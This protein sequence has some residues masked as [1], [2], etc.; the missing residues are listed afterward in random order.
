MLSLAVPAIPE[1][2][3][4]AY[5]IKFDGYRTEASRPEAECNLRSCYNANFNARFPAIARALEALPDETVNDG[6]TVAYDA[7]SHPSFNV[8]QK[9]LSEKPRLHL[10]PSTSWSFG[11][12]PDAQL[13][14]RTGPGSC[15][16][17]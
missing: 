2:T 9:H 15:I 16:A 10:S 14:R 13:A 3:E 4:W 5:E 11:H 7:K 6:E 17:K 1:G 8:L 12:G